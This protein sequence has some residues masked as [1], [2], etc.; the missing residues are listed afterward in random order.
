MAKPA[1]D[2]PLTDE[3]IR[4][5]DEFLASESVPKD[6]MGVSMLD[7]FLTGIAVHP[8]VIMPSEWLPHVWGGG[9]QAVFEDQKEAGRIFGLFM[10]H[11]NDILSA[12]RDDPDRFEPLFYER[13]VEGKTY[14]IVDD[15]CAG[16]MQAVNKVRPKSWEPMQEEGEGVAWLLPMEM[17]ASDKGWGILESA[18]DQEKA[19]EEWASKIVPAVR[20]INDFWTEHRRK[21]MEK[22]RVSRGPAPRVVPVRTKPKIARND[23]CPCGSGKKFKRCCGAEKDVN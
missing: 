17:F 11:L 9:E 2:D 16:F 10:R 19:H 3:E 20:A 8:D 23:P 18:E 6:T 12:L 7:G 1:L 5:L 4:E 22:S 15:W 13:E 14:T 21:A